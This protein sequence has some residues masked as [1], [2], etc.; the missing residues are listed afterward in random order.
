[1]LPW[2]LLNF[3]MTPLT[4]HAL[5]GEP[6]LHSSHGYPCP[7]GVISSQATESHPFLKTL[8]CAKEDSGREE[9]S[10]YR[11]VRHNP[12]E[13]LSPCSQSCPFAIAICPVCGG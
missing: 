7:D 8:L 3:F 1:M 10:R 2:G 4:Q 9:L 5:P 13:H 12:L 6:L 11:Q